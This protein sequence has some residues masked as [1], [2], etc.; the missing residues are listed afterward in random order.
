[1]IDNLKVF[2]RQ[3]S[4]LMLV[5]LSKNRG[6]RK[7]SAKLAKEIDCTY[8]HAIK[9]INTFEEI[10]L[11]TTNHP[12]G[13]IRDIELTKKGEEVARHIRNAIDRLNEK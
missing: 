1:M 8:S 5:E 13:R 9:I 4:T 11:V 2:F 6:S 3:K 12:K 10:G 7:Y